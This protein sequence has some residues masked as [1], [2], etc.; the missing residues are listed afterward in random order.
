MKLTYSTN[1][2]ILGG[3]IAGLWLLNRM[4]AEGYEPILFETESLGGRQTLASQGII[5]GGLKYALKGTL[6]K[7]TQNIANMPNRWK[8]CLNGGGEVDLTGVR[9]L[10]ENYYMWSDGGLRSRLKSYL[11]SK[12]LRGKVDVV[13][14][15]SYPNFFRESSVKG[16]LYKLPDFVID[17]K[18]LLQ[19]LVSGNNDRIFSLANCKY[20]FCSE[21]KTSKQKL[22]IVIQDKVVTIQAEL[23]IFCAGE[24]N[25]Q[26]IS[27]AELNTIKSQTRPLHMVYLRK[28]NLPKVYVHCIGSNFNLNPLVTV[29]SHEAKNGQIVWYLGGDIAESGIDKSKSQQIKAAEQLMLKT[30]PWMNLSSAIW[31]SFLINRSEADIQSGF[32]PDDAII[33]DEKNILVAWPTKLTLVPSLADKAIA[34]AARMERSFLKTTIP[35]DKLRSI[36][37]KPSLATTHWD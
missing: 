16:T 20:K 18:S 17:T 36:F 13:S 14:K 24:G 34:Y 37:D 1:I 10:D 2:V 21:E 29:T 4:K 27:K 6:G 31:E 35:L 11:G 23:F 8:K 28:S 5:H 12:S 3:G 15:D 22:E 9:L 7:E 33:K 25:S 19:K 30:F 26:L 32:R